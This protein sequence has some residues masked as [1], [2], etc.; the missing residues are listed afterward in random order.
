MDPS[1]STYDGTRKMVL[2]PT[3]LAGLSDC[4]WVLLVVGVSRLTLLVQ[5]REE[6]LSLSA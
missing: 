2:I 4:L 6:L 5:I 3:T 1:F